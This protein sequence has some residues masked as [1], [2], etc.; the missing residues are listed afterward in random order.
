MN[1]SQ[2]LLKIEKFYIL[3]TICDITDVSN[4]LNKNPFV[5]S[6]EL[7]LSFL[8]WISLDMETN[9]FTL[10]KLIQKDTPI[11]NLKIKIN[12]L[13]SDPLTIMLVNQGCLL[14]MLLYIIAI[15]ALAN[16]VNTD[17]MMKGTQIGDHEIEMVNFA[18]DSTI[19]L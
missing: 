17:K 19:F 11:S 7:I 12:G 9:S 3:S 14:S 2:K 10:L 16:F 4:K 15:E 1:T 13:Q 5:M 6:L 8:L 18:D